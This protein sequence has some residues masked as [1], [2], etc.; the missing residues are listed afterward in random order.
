MLKNAIADADG[1]A[2]KLVDAFKAGGDIHAVSQGSV[3]Q[4]SRRPD[5]ADKNAGT[6][7]PDPYPDSWPSFRLPG[8]VDALHAPCRPQRTGAGTQDMVGA[9]N[10]GIPEIHDAVANELV[11]R[12]AFFRYR[13]G[14]SL[15]LGRA[16]NQKVGRRE[17]FGATREILQIGTEDAQAS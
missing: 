2:K 12:A 4:P 6:I 3:A 5:I 13:A 11:D 17:S 8:V 1:G 9:L 10:R 7:E 16:L 14:H 15:G